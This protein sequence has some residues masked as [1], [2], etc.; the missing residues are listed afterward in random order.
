MTTEN[1][2]HQMYAS[3]QLA[4]KLGETDT[5]VS[6]EQQRAIRDINSKIIDLMDKYVS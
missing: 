1:A 2:I 3:G 6:V 5:E 4:E